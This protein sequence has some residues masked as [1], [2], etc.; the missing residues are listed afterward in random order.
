MFDSDWLVARHLRSPAG[1]FRFLQRQSTGGI[2]TV[3]IPRC[4]LLVSA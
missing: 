3:Q 2:K 1:Q 4:G